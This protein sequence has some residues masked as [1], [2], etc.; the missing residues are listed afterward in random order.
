[1][2]GVILR[3]RAHAEQGT[4]Q[5]VRQNSHLVNPPASNFEIQAPNNQELAVENQPLRVGQAYAK[6]NRLPSFS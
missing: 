2:H 5:H 3:S 4:A 1:M 6:L